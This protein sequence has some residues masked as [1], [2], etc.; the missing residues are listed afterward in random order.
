MFRKSEPLDWADRWFSDCIVASHKP[1]FT[2]FCEIDI[3]T[4]KKQL[5]E[6]KQKNTPSNVKITLTHVFVW[7]LGQIVREHA[8]LNV[9]LKGYQRYYLDAVNIGISVAGQSFI[10]PVLVIK[11]VE[12]MNLE[13]VAKEFEVR[14]P[15]VKREEMRLLKLLRTFGWLV[16]FGLLRRGL[17][18]LL[19]RSLRFRQ[20][21][22]GTFQV[23]SVPSVDI[24]TPY[25]TNSSAIF[26][27]G[28]AQLKS[29]TNV[30]EIDPRWKVHVTFTAN[31]CIFDGSRGS[32]LLNALKS[33]L[34]HPDLSLTHL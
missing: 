10:A 23:T 14:V 1:H 21:T 22:S 34:E 8:D 26:A 16:P 29:S 5:D 6:I 30:N 20:K 31:H 24:I 3:T 18:A 13:S 33:F 28:Q 17:L 27:I 32:R 2:L 4:V 19:F 12:N 11:N 9:M 25:L 7:A 15:K